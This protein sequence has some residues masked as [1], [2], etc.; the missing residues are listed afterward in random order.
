M[1][2]NGTSGV[3]RSN[4]GGS[5]S[6]GGPLGGPGRPGKRLVTAQQDLGDYTG[7]GVPTDPF[8]GVPLVS[9][10]TRGNNLKSDSAGVGGAGD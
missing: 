3:G 7:P 1:A 5:L 10:K 4:G 8:R 9:L 6:T 2:G